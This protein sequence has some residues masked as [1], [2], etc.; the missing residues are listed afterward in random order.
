MARSP[1]SVLGHGRSRQLWN[2]HLEPASRQREKVGELFST[3]GA[4]MVCG[5]ASPPSPE[6]VA[7]GHMLEQ[8]WKSAVL[9]VTASCE[10]TLERELIDTQNI[11]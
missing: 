4:E 3:D 10:S 6:P 2:S 11:L 1:C 9:G 7:A 8:C 5:A